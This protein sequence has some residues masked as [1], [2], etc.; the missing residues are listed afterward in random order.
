MTNKI[1]SYPLIFKQ[2]V[3]EF[4]L[5]NPDIHISKLLT[6]FKISNGSLY[7]WIRLFKNNTLAEK[8][9]YFKKSI[10]LPH[11]KCFIRAYVIRKIN[12]IYKSLIK[13]IKRKFNIIIS[14]TSIYSVLKKLNITRKKIK[15]R[16]VL[17]NKKLYKTKVK[18][19]IKNIKNISHNDIISIDEC[20]IDTHINSTHGWSDKGTRINIKKFMG[21]RQ[22]FTIICAISNKKIMYYECIKNSATSIIFK[23]FITNLFNLCNVQNKVLLLDNASIHRSAILYE[24]I[25]TTNS[26]IIFNAPYSPQYNPIEQVFSKL[27]PLVAQKNNNKSVI[28]L[29]KNINISLKKI[30]SKDLKNFYKNSLAYI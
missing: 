15:Y 4:Y 21:Q 1:N 5:S 9:K 19:F 6:I 24:F 25:K 28:K 29:K 30:K 2:K 20:S 27:K 7:N 18:T 13:A 11:I 22:R 3:V 23:S 14:K 12:F 16:Y 26:K 8:K 10:I 17:S